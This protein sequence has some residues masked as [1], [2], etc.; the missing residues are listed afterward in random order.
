MKSRLARR[1]S[2][3]SFVGG[4]VYRASGSHSPGFL[5]SV[6]W[7]RTDIM[8][9]SFAPAFSLLFEFFSSFAEY[10]SCSPDVRVSNCIAQPEPRDDRRRYRRRVTFS[11]SIASCLVGRGRGACLN[12]GWWKLWLGRDV[13]PRSRPIGLVESGSRFL[14]QTIV[15]GSCVYE[16]GES[17]TRAEL[18]T[19]SEAT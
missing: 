4:C 2:T 7:Q 1:F 5:A 18:G 19:D 10:P 3:I 6:L 13:S 12:I 14:R 15:T 8:D 17:R 9:G 11:S 16:D